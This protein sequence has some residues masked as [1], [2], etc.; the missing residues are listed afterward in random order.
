MPF[1]NTCPTERWQASTFPP[2]PLMVSLSNHHPSLREAPQSAEGIWG[3]G[4]GR[5]VWRNVPSAYQGATCAPGLPRRL[6]PSHNDS[7]LPA[8]LMVSLS[9]HHLSLREAP[10]SAE[11]IWG[12]G[13]ARPVRRNVPSAYQ[14]ATSATPD[15]RAGCPPSRHD[16]RLPAPLMVSLLNH[17]LSLREAPQSAEAIWGGVVGRP[18]RRERP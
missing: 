11:A 16:R 7:R 6:P 2:A 14:E 10:Q 1:D 12:S 13:V 8:P 15:C 5:P 18:V 17:Q 9:N 3:C 4:V